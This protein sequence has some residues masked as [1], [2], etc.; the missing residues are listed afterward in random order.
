MP[1]WSTVAAIR[2]RT[3]SSN[4]K[5]LNTP[6]RSYHIIWKGLACILPC[7]VIS[8][9]GSVDCGCTHTRKYGVQTFRLCSFLFWK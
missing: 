7:A 1:A 8:G 6:P 4:L 9:G 2:E 5:I 3:A